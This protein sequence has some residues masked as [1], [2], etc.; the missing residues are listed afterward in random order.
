ML[1]TRTLH[2]FLPLGT[3]SCCQVPFSLQVAC[4]QEDYERVFEELWNWMCKEK[5]NKMEGKG[6]T[7]K[8]G[9]EEEMERIIA[10][11]PVPGCTGG[12]V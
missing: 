4:F 10:F 1:G 8:R 12:N 11:F 2:N 5:W 3:R 7:R 6:K 9:G